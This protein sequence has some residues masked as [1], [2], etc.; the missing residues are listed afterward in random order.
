MCTLA[1]ASKGFCRFSAP[2][3]LALEVGYQDTRLCTCSVALKGKLNRAG[4]R[5]PYDGFKPFICSSTLLAVWTCILTLAPRSTSWPDGF[6]ILQLC[7]TA[8]SC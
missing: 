8:S 6:L 2:D 4:P 3:W 7:L 1:A 5:N